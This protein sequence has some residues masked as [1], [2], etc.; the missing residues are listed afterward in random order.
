M[1]QIMRHIFRADLTLNAGTWEIVII[2]N[3]Y[4]CWKLSHTA[5]SSVGISVGIICTSVVIL[6]KKFY[7]E[8]LNICTKWCEY[9]ELRKE[10]KSVS[11]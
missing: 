10:G 11:R 6:F 3:D 2:I 8:S 5:G 7:I 4:T 9:P 1:N